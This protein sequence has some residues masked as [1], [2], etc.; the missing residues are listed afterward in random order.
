DRASQLLA[1]GVP[2]GLPKSYRALADHGDVPR[3]TLQYHARGRR[4]KEEKAQSQLYLFPWEEKA[5]VEFLVH[6]D[7][8]G[9]SV[10]V[11]H[12]CSIAFGL[13]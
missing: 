7:A 12:L 11:K 5:L 3:T 4:S 10:Q 9:H 13:A 1:Q 6:Q 2:H 8:L